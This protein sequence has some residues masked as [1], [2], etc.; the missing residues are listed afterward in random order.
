MNNRTVLWLSG[1]LVV[2][3]ILATVGQRD[4]QPQ[5][6]SD[7]LFLPALSASLDD[8][9]RIEFTGSGGEVIATLERGESNWVVLEKSSY[10]ADLTKTRNL[11]LS[12]AETQILEFKT[13]DPMLHNRLGV[14]ALASETASG[15]GIRLIGPA[16]SV[17]VIVGDAEGNSQRYVRRQGED[18]SYLINRDPDIGTS[19]TDWLDTPV[20]DVEGNR[21]QY[22]TVTRPDGG[23]VIISKGAREQANFTVDNIPQGRALS[24]DSIPNVIGNVLEDLTLDDVEQDTATTEEKIVTEFKT[25]DGITITAHSFERGDTAWTSF[26]AMVDPT[27]SDVS[28]EA[29]SA[30]E[31]EVI[32]INARVGG[33]RYQ[34][35]AFKFEQLTREMEDL[36]QDIEEEPVG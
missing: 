25:F 24:Y 18:Q 3:A 10:R 12:L 33:W 13:A 14:E 8:V 17:E 35:P 11:L 31:T 15:V 7:Q 16:E 27:L 4:Q 6:T 34:I 21:V 26:I 19:A 23:E 22:V 9:R 1:T 29:R 30:A 20:I 32:E 2:L 36:L 28:E 5:T